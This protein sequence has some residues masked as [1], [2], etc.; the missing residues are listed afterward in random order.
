[1]KISVYL[2]FIVLMLYVSITGQSIN[3]LIPKN[4]SF[5][6]Q[7]AQEYGR[8]NKGFWD[9]PGGEDKIKEGADIQVYELSDKAKDRRYMIENS[10]KAGFVRIHIEG[11]AGYLD[12]S[13]K[14]NNNGQNYLVS[15]ND[16]NQNYSFK[17]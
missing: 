14:K 4:E 5:F 7:S 8:S 1:M 12:I 13:S 2:V 3:D 17:P 9:I 10:P 11:V 16:W 15:N 6:I